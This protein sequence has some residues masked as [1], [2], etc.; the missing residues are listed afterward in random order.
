MFGEL[1]QDLYVPFTVREYL[2]SAGTVTI[3][4][5]LGLGG[6]TA[7]AMH[8]GGHKSGSSD[9]RTYAVLAPSATNSNPDNN[10]AGGTVEGTMAAFNVV[11]GSFQAS[12]SFTAANANYIENVF[13]A[14][15]LATKANGKSSPY[16][17]YKIYKAAVGAHASASAV[18]TGSVQNIALSQDYQNAYTP[19]VT[20]Q[21]LSLIHI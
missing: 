3:V 8:I 18:V 15:P 13:S 9:W 7:A 16:Y 19:Y 20:S 11:T 12:C 14:N 6:Y 10:F 1:S 17:L 5:V 2:R 21:K 4:R